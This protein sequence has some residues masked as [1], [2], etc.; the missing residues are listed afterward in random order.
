LLLSTAFFLERGPEQKDAVAYGNE[1]NAKNQKIKS[2]QKNSQHSTDP[3]DLA[4]QLLVRNAQKFKR[5]MK[6]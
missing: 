2:L 1:M 6:I 5:K 3:K 4:L